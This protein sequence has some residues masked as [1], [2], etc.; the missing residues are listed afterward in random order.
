MNSKIEVQ[1]KAAD[2]KDKEKLKNYFQFYLHDLSE[3]AETLNVNSLGRFENDDVDIFFQKENLIPMTINIED[4]IIGFIFLN[5]GR[6]VDYVINDIFILR[7]YRNKG[8][9]KA[10]INK[11]FKL[12]PGKYGLIELIKNR[13][14]I[15]FWHSVFHGNNIEYLEDEAIYDGEACITQKFTVR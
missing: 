3:F 9:G 15:E 6:T 8:L 12:Y 1:I 10:V 4:E 7:K 14:A 2:I 5:K 11:L 13:P